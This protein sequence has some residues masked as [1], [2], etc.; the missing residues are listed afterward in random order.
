MTA[1]MENMVNLRKFG[2]LVAFFYKKAIIFAADRLLMEK[3]VTAHR[4][5]MVGM[6]I[7]M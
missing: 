5:L 2:F 6:S 1:L 3:Y 4:K 7:R